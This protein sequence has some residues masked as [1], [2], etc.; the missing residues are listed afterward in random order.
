MKSFE[1]LTEREIL[2]LAISL[3]EEDARVYADF[4]DGLREAFPAS[5]AVFEGMRQEELGRRRLIDF[6][7]KQ[8]TVFLIHSTLAN[9]AKR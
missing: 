2:A 1:S 3:E 9:C 6:L 4:V 8:R 7:E 5:A